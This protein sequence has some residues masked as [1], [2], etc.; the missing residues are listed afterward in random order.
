MTGACNGSE[1]VQ[2]YRAGPSQRKKGNAWGIT[3]Q[4]IK[5]ITS[6]GKTPLSRPLNRPTPRIQVVRRRWN[7]SNQSKRFEKGS[8]G[9]RRESGRGGTVSLPSFPSSLPSS[10]FSAPF[11]S[12]P[13]YLPYGTLIP[14]PRSGGLRSSF[15]QGP[16]RRDLMSR[17]AMIEEFDLDQDGA[18]NEQEFLAIMLDG[19]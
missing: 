5:L 17:K 19:E 15:V 8:Q 13:P 11:C 10:R 16:P 4:G 2:L 1:A 3:T 12:L 6:D 9:I 7:R 18:I 14:T